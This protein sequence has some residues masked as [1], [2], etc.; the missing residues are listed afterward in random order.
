MTTRCFAMGCDN[1]GRG[2]TVL[3]SL[4]RPV[5]AW[6]RWRLASEHQPDIAVIDIG[7]K[8]L[9]GIEATS[10]ILRHSPKTAVLILSMHSDERYVMRAL[11]AGARGYI[12]Q[13]IR[14]RR[15]V[16]RHSSGAVAG[17]SS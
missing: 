4:P 10:Q 2:S 11:K 1:P 8:E 15:I 7:M 13:E 14:R 12:F 5:P 6:R 3:K 16:A 9:N 17:T